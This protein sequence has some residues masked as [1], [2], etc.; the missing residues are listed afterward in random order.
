MIDILLINPP[1]GNSSKRMS[2][3]FASSPPLGL[4]YIGSHL[5]QAGYKIK[6]IDFSVEFFDRDNF[7]N[8]LFNN[9][10]RMIGITTYFESFGSLYVIIEFIR[11]KMP[12]IPIVLGGA[13]ATFKYELFFSSMNIDYIIMGE[14]EYS[15]VHLADILLRNNTDKLDLV[16]GL[17]YKK[18][19]SL[20][21]TPYTRILDLNTLYYPDRELIDLSKYAYPFTLSTARGCPGNCIFCSSKQYWGS[22]MC[23]RSVDSIYDEIVYLK[24][25]YQMKYFFIVDDTF[26]INP[27]RTAAFAQKLILNQLN[28]FWGCESR[29]DIVTKE[30]LDKLYESGCRKIQ[31]GL[32]SADNNILRKLK[33]NITKEQVYKAVSLASQ[34]GFDVNVS[35]IIGHPFDTHE[36]VKNTL[37]FVLG[38]RKKFNISPYASILVPYPGTDIYQNASEY[39]LQ[40]LSEDFDNYRIDKAIIRTSHLT[41]ND[42]RFYY[43]FFLNKLISNVD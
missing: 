5:K 33:K 26:T 43:Q 32:E 36:T 8:Y 7:E 19:D 35:F 12:H 39:G 38:L 28:L 14:G 30:L 42:L 10:P 40:I 37:D 15:F 18:N 4:M 3:S 9:L 11:K 6:L 20:H 13:A 1:T 21:I 41:D 16:K 31:F 29:V 22:K 24:E 2:A 25:M 17:V 34:I 27:K 23:L